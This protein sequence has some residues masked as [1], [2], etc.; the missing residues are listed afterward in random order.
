MEWISVDERLPEE[1]KVLAVVYGEV[2][3]VFFSSG[4]F[5]YDYNPYARIPENICPVSHW[6]PLPEPPK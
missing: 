6:M 1:M 2:L 5:Y 3:Q 4:K